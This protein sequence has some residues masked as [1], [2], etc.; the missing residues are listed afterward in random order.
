M[1]LGQTILTT[2]LLIAES[3]VLVH[4]YAYIEVLHCKV[5]PLI[6]SHLIKTIDKTS[7]QAVLFP[8]IWGSNLQERSKNV[9]ILI[10]IL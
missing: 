10:Y 6:R 4:C 8:R 9:G 5:L 1:S 2:K 3:L 7:L